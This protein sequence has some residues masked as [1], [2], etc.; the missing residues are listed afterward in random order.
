M[1]SMQRKPESTRAV[2][3]V[4]LHE[5]LL[6]GSTSVF[7]AITV[8]MAGCGALGSWTALFLA[9][10]GIKNFRLIDRDKVE[11]HNLSTQFFAKWNLGQSKV[12]ALA[13]ELYRRHR[14]KVERHPV[15]LVE[16]NAAALLDNCHL[17]ICTFDNK[18]SRQIVQKNALELQPE[19]IK[20]G[21]DFLKQWRNAVTSAYGVQGPMG[22]LMAGMHGSEYY[23]HIGWAENFIP[24]DDP[25][26]TLIDPCNYPL[27]ASLCVTLSGLIAETAMHYLI[28]GEKLRVRSSMKEIFE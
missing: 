26:E 20:Y 15:E 19:P 18:K 9:N 23:M 28:Y 16:R 12:Q 17:I 22:C 4:F 1:Q 24:P 21:D 3:R 14:C 8:T 10:S 5:E 6:R 25:P 11:D 13:T 7:D 27:S 2:N